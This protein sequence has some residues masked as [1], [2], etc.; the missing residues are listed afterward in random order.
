[1]VPGISVTQ[2]EQG[3]E[4]LKLGE[5]CKLAKS[6]L[7]EQRFIQ[8]EQASFWSLPKCCCFLLGLVSA[9]FFL[10]GKPGSCPYAA[11]HRSLWL[12]WLN[13]VQ[14]KTREQASHSLPWLVKSFGSSFSLASVALFN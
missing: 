7:A 5:L 10:P 2:E 12:P 8:G 14:S 3:Q 4:Q 6:L 13:P 11:Q 9:V 1:L